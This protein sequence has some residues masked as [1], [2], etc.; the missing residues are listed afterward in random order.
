MMNSTGSASHE[1]RKPASYAKARTITERRWTNGPVYKL[2]AM[3][4]VLP[5]SVKKIAPLVNVVCMEMVAVSERVMELDTANCPSTKRA[6]IPM[7]AVRETL[8]KVRVSTAVVG[9]K[10]AV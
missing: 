6:G 1:L 10:I 8:L 3:D 9:E 5:S 4:G 7:G 2:E